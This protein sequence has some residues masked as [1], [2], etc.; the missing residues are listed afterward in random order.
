MRRT[1]SRF[2]E[3]ELNDA[4]VEAESKGWKLVKKGQEQH[5]YYN[6]QYHYS[7]KHSVVTKGVEP[8]G[9]WIAVVEKER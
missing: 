7:R 8:Y 4:I 2:R 5:A 1:I 3:S 9:K 6:H